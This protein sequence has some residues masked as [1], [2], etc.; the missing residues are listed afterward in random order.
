MELISMGQRSYNLHP[1]WDATLEIY[2]AIRNI[3]EEHGLRYFAGF[4]TL[5]GAVRH[6]GFIPWDDDFDL[7]MPRPDYEVFMRLSA[8]ELPQNL[9]WQSVETDPN[10]PYRFGKVRETRKDR[11]A[12]VAQQSRLRLQ[13]GIYVDFFPLDGLPTTDVG[14]LLWCVKRALI[15]RGSDGNKWF[16][17]MLFGMYGTQQENRLNFTKW[18]KAIPFNKAK[19]VGT[20]SP[21]EASA[22]PNRWWHPKE[23]FDSYKEVPFEDRIIR[24][25][26]GTHEL[27]TAIYGD[28]MKLPPEKERKPSHQVLGG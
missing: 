8:E 25:P 27:L 13:D 4:G 24:I 12:D 15:R 17:K 28:Y 22:T 7:Y 6:R 2:D 26:I 10:Y 9:I 20:S 5:I 16:F 19:R 23:W 3:C 14:R 18:M 1:L 21:Y 11:I